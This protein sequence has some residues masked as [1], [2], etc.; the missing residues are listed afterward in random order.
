MKD[1]LNLDK[2]VKRTEDNKVFEVFIH[3]KNK[4]LLRHKSDSLIIPSKEFKQGLMVRKTFDFVNEHEVRAFEKIQN[5]YYSK[6]TRL[7][8][9][10]VFLSQ[11]LLETHDEL[12]ALQKDNNHLKNTLN[13]SNKVLERLA[14]KFYDNLYEANKVI[15]TNISASMEETFNAHLKLEPHLYIHISNYIKDVAANP[16]KYEK[17]D[18]HL[19]KLQE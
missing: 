13:K 14:D 9:K 12:A 16:E 19:T 8:M 17:K 3:K 5:D 7:K 4:V 1:K 15:V 18:Y 11:I 10:S 2:Y 6:L